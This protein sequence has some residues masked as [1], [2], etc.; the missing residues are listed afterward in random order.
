MIESPHDLNSYTSFKLKDTST[1]GMNK[2]LL[3]V[4]VLEEGI[5]SNVPWHVNNDSFV[6]DDLRKL[7]DRENITYDSWFWKNDNSYVVSGN[8]NE[9]FKKMQ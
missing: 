3:S 5:S 4:E 2:L 9:P 8:R 7:K 6:A 1:S